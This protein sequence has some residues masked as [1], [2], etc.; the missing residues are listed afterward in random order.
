MTARR[1]LQEFETHDLDPAIFNH[2]AHVQMGWGMLRK[3]EFLE[4]TLKYAHNIH[5]IATKAGAGK[6]FNMTITIA[7]MSLI[8]ERMDTDGGDDFDLFLMQNQ[9]LL[10]KD[11][12][13]QWYPPETLKSDQARKLFLMPKVA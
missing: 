7:F 8:A 3:Y 13:A 6:K 10:S 1:M 4:A 5:A 11:L 12:M 2:R 9:D